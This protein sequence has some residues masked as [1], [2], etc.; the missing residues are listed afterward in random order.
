MRR[1]VLG[2]AIAFAAIA[3]SGLRADDTQIAQQIVEQ[4]KAQKSQGALRGFRIDLQVEDGTVL[5]TGHVANAEQ[6][7]LAVE[8]AQG[9]DGV[10]RVVEDLD[11]AAAATTEEAKAPAPNR[12]PLNKLSP[13][14]LLGNRKEQSSHKPT[15]EASDEAQ[16]AEA[17]PVDV[18]AESSA[19]YYEAAPAAAAQISDQQIA[20]DVFDRLQQ[21]KQSGH[22]QGFHLDM[23]VEEGS[24]I[25]DGRVSTPEQKQLALEV[26]RRVPGV[27]QVV[28]M[29]NVDS[30]PMVQ[31]MPASVTASIDGS[32][33]RTAQ[34]QAQLAAN[35]PAALQPTPAGAIPQ[36]GYYVSQPGV[37]LAQPM[38]IPVQYASPTGIA[39]VRYDH[40][41][42]PA[43]AWPS[44]AAYPN[45]A[46][47]TYP[48]QYSPSAWPYIGPFYPYPQVPLGWRK[49]TL[50]W[51]DGW[52]QLD[53]KEK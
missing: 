14:K 47:V 31:V 42:L 29:I 51:D 17:Q 53:F 44:Y 35:A 26:A 3:P 12:F 30:Q 2:L 5:L 8:I 13:L 45:Y 34:P 37:G 39:Q 21:Y 22:L 48:R 38:P 4:I 1:A 36:G 23:R 33:R 9:V 46:A 20:Q 11:I 19:D 41:Q 10:K 27:F 28:D 49:V 24:V 43:Y 32:T 50:E 25:L 40:P 6:E 52:W 16:P 15:S 18:A 7:Q